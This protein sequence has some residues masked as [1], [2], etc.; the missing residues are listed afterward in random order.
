[1]EE[2]QRVWAYNK[3]WIMA[4]SQQLYNKVREMA[5]DNQWTPEKDL[6]FKRILEEAANTKPTR[7]TLV[8]AYQHVWGYFK[9]ICTDDEKNTY[10]KLLVT[11]TPN[12]DQLGLFLKQLA[13]KY[14][15]TYLLESRII[16]EI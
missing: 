14:Q 8:T 6:I 15:I 9:K 2:W 12:N 7:A 5:K 3:Y 10:L 1:M 11:L 4:R 13:I 16:K